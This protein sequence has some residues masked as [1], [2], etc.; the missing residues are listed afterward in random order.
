MKSKFE[1]MGIGTRFGAQLIDWIILIIVYWILGF[2]MFGTTTWSVA[3]APAMTITTVNSII[4]LLY[5]VILEGSNGATIGK[6]ALKIKVVKEDGSKCDIS[7]ALIRNI[8][9]IID[10]LPFIYII[11]MI[12]ISRSEKKQRFGDGIAKTI[13]IKEGPVTM[14]TSTP[15]A[16]TGKAKFCVECGTDLPKDAEFC[17]SCGSKQ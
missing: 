11:G 17:G 4:G 3:G 15:S 1:Y 16:P 9:R 6:K 10:I 12:L 7:A 14:R 13:V 5:F 2:A 8:L